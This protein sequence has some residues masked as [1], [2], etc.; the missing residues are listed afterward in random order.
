MASEEYPRFW[1]A[2]RRIPVET[3]LPEE[4]AVLRWWLASQ[5][6]DTRAERREA[7][8]LVELQPLQTRA[9]ERLI[10]LT[11]EAGDLEKPAASSVKRLRSIAPED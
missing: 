6:A 3:L 4:V 10:E 2:A 11:R 1:E 5:D 9:P 8:R 7:E